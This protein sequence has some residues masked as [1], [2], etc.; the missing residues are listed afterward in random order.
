MA[1]LIL[2]DIN[3]LI[4]AHNS[5]DPRYAPAKRWLTELLDGDEHTGFCW[6]T[7]CGF[8]RLSTSAQVVTA[9]L[10]L[11][12][13]FM[14]VRV[15]L[16]APNSILLGKTSRHLAVLETTASGADATGARFSDAVLAAI[17]IEHN[18]VLATLDS[19]FRRFDGLK[20]VNPL[21]TD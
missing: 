18:A 4:Y 21:V 20:W 14:V 5:G 11:S 15:W 2:P 12:E 13:A 3:L 6:E 1:S 8:I 19:D 16:E 10:T 9:P 7:I 17:V